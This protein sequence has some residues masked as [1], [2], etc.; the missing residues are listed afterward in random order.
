MTSRVIGSECFFINGLEDC[1]LF[2]LDVSHLISTTSSIVC[3][4][5]Y[6]SRIESLSNAFNY[7]LHSTVALD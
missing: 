5:R 4:S 6:K 3:E 1:N 2:F 7:F